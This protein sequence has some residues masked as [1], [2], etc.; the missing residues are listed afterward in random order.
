MVSGQATIGAGA[1]LIEL[2]DFMPS[3]KEAVFLNH[4]SNPE[5]YV[6]PESLVRLMQITFPLTMSA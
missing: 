6:I 3:C 1:A 2:T 4:G 5:A